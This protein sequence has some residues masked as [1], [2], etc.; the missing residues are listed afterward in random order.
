[1][2]AGVQSVSR[3]AGA[4]LQNAC[5]EEWGMVAKR[6]ITTLA[7]IVALGGSV[8]ADAQ[9]TPSP[10]AGTREVALGSA[11]FQRGTPVP[12][13]VDRQQDIP[14][15]D[16]AGP[17]V[18]LLADS[19]VLAADQT[20]YHVHRATVAKTPAAL[21]SVAR[22]AIDFNP[23][24]QSVEL[25]TVAIRRDGQR[26]DRLEASKVSFLQ[27]EVG[28][29]SSVYTGN[30]TASLVIPDLRVG[31]IFEVEYTVRGENPVFGG[32][33][34]QR[35][36]W[37][38]FYATQ[39]R[40]ATLFAPVGRNINW[41]IEGDDGASKVQPV[42]TRSGALRKLRWQAEKLPRFE[43]DV[44]APRGLLPH[45][46]LMLSEFKD[47]DDVAQWAQGLFSSARSDNDEL[48][49]LVESFR[50]LPTDDERI[51]AALAWVQGQ[52]RYVSLSF[53]ESSHRPAPAT[54]TLERRFG[55]CKDKSALLVQL[56]AN[57]GIDAHPVLL[58]ASR[59]YGLTRDLPSPDSFDHAIVVAT[60][61]NQA[62][63]LDPTRLGQIG[64][65]STMGQ[66]WEGADVLVVKPGTDAL[67][68]VV[69]SAPAMTSDT[70]AERLK[71]TKFGY[72]GSLHVE[73]TFTGGL[74]EQ[75]RVA[76]AE[77]S[78]ERLTKFLLQPYEQRN[79]GYVLSKN[80]AYTD[81][82]A[83]NRVTVFYDFM[84]PLPAIQS[85]DRWSAYYIA[86]NVER[87][88]PMPESATRRQPLALP[89]RGVYR[90][91]LEVLFPEGTH[92]LSD[93]TLQERKLSGLSISRS[94]TF[95]GN[96]GTMQIE[97]KV[98]GPYLPAKETAAYMGAL[99]W[100]QS[101]SRES[102]S[103]SKAALKAW[104]ESANMSVRE[105]FEKR[106][107]AAIERS[108]K[109]IEGGKLQGGDLAN[110]YC[111]RA[112][113]SAYLREFDKALADLE[114][115]E[116]LNPDAANTL[117]CR[118]IVLVRADRI[119]E[120]IAA[121]DRAIALD[122]D[123][124]PYFMRGLAKFYREQFESAA[125][126]FVSA[127]K[128]SQGNRKFYELWL[129]MAN[130]RLGR[131]PDPAVKERSVAEARGEWPAPAVAMMYGSMTPDELLGMVNS[132]KGDDRELTLVEAYH[133]V[134]EWN[135]AHGDK[136]RAI[137]YFHKTVDVGAVSYTEHE[138]ARRELIRLEGTK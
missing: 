30:V 86:H 100:L 42:E 76:M 34:V 19:Q 64:K 106:Y 132:R 135:L 91:S 13:W 63:F 110:A 138:S 87:V 65:V 71:I 8:G 112:F 23:G 113:S 51:S 44:G 130:A 108:T 75:M 129:A 18:V 49:K 116:K 128:W 12:S 56:L 107:R 4:L 28:L 52:V 7:A 82:K 89:L 103:V 83:N 117:N 45:R 43:F 46:T 80:L 123:H 81:D 3:T 90:Y 55:D 29:D 31:D 58:S 59:V 74:A 67:T 15:S 14:S 32:K 21:D 122:P 37:D 105:T 109:G 70:I 72:T 9:V 119:D 88:L 69:A 39:L 127:S 77:V 98:T 84:V 93:P 17:A 6:W 60:V 120:G 131:E 111:E 10:P 35:L 118:G 136:Q 126:D 53:G 41:R 85:A 57:L 125:A 96:R 68:Q 26:L 25:H 92:A 78:N 66:L 61:G 5:Q 40:R 54:L 79:M 101:I 48:L 50:A 62:Y 22:F 27:R 114:H 133:A 95:R 33:L 47:W 121:Y 73:R 16:L 97:V 20:S 11:Q 99:K 124:G 102:F 1:M 2:K 115:A 94:T 134:A 137:E 24:Y 36:S 38:S 104:D